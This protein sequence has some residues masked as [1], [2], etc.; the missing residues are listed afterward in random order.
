[1]QKT[2]QVL[3]TLC[4]MNGDGGYRMSGSKHE[5]LK[6]GISECILRDNRETAG[7]L[8]KSI[9]VW[10]LVVCYGFLGCNSF[11]GHFLSAGTVPK[12]IS[13]WC[14]SFESLEDVEQLLQQTW[15]RD[16]DT[17]FSLNCCR[18]GT[19]EAETES[20]VTHL[21]ARK[22]TGDTFV[23]LEFDRRVTKYDGDVEEVFGSLRVSFGGKEGK[24][25]ILCDA[26]KHH[27]SSEGRCTPHQSV[28]RLISNGLLDP[29]DLD[30]LPRRVHAALLETEVSLATIGVLAGGRMTG[31]Y[32]CRDSINLDQTSK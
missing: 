22:A 6:S 18:I 5:E 3:R 21:A 25:E 1:M 29:S 4:V 12:I 19:V 15:G 20:L 9:P 14:I 16:C 23:G 30:L 32:D 13:L 8:M 7:T 31:W 17:R 11:C 27:S 24:C 28:G 10:Y 2:V 26:F